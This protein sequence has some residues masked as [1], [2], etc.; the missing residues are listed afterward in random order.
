[1][2]LVLA[3]VAKHLLILVLYLVYLKLWVVR[4]IVL[5]LCLIESLG[6]RVVVGQVFSVAQ[7]SLVVASPCPVLPVCL[8]CFF[9]DFL[10]LD[11][12][13]AVSIVLARRNSGSEE[14][15]LLLLLLLSEVLLSVIVLFFFFFWPFLQ[16]LQILLVHL[17]SQVLLRL[18]L[19]LRLDLLRCFFL[20]FIYN[21]GWWFLFRVLFSFLAFK[22]IILIRFI[23]YLC[24]FPVVELNA[25]LFWTVVELRNVRDVHHWA[26][27]VV[28]VNN[29]FL[30]SSCLFVLASK[31]LLRLMSICRILFIYLCLRMF[32]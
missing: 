7:P 21:Q 19:F 25:H 29:Y 27:V 32:G 30:L 9:Q 2:G 17:L 22:V 4:L 6:N 20:G 26:L 1:M 11:L 18:Q 10:H 23:L 14:F 12:L 28:I 13:E 24:L 31:I 15:A 8:P 16:L 3:S 5:A